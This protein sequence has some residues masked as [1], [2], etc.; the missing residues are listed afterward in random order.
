M[1]DLVQ[2]LPN[3]G[4]VAFMGQPQGVAPIANFTNFGL[5]AEIGKDSRTFY[6]LPPPLASMRKWCRLLTPV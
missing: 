3:G 4:N 6:A 2:A 5:G 1:N